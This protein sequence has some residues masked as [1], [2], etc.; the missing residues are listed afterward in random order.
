MKKYLLLPAILLTFFSTSKLIA[1]TQIGIT[2]ITDET[3]N[4]DKAFALAEFITQKKY[5]AAAGALEPKLVDYVYNTPYGLS[6]KLTKMMAIFVIYKD[7]K[8]IAQISCEN[9]WNLISAALDAEFAKLG[10]TASGSK[11]KIDEGDGIK[12][13]EKRMAGNLPGAMSFELPK[14]IHSDEFKINAAEIEYFEPKDITRE[15]KELHGRYGS[16]DITDSKFFKSKDIPKE[17]KDAVQPLASPVGKTM[18]MPSMYI[19]YG[20]LLMEQKDYET[21]QHCY[22]QAIAGSYELIGSS[23]DKA[24]IRAYAF[25]KLATLQTGL[26]SNRVLMAKLYNACAAINKSAKL[27]D[28][29]NKENA[30]YYSNVKTIQELCL[31]AEQNAKSARASRFTAAFGA[32]SS[33]LGQGFMSTGG[34]QYASLSSSV[35]MMQVTMEKSQEQLIEN[36]RFKEELRSVSMDINSDIFITDAGGVDNR[37]YFLAG[38]VYYFLSQYPDDVKDVLEEYATD[39]PALTKLLADYYGATTKPAKNKAIKDLYKHL[40]KIEYTISNFEARSMAV[41]EKYIA[42]F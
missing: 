16:A 24:N 35:Q 7:A 11:V 32:V 33:G 26:S 4:T 14:N 10:F 9:D 36:M 38:E 15:L 3:S 31:K 27:G 17:L 34:A 13:Y 1:Q 2:V 12:V 19:S 6:G 40:G 5:T 23:K 20:N 18:L 39:K 22:I 28:V 37:N 25:A 8:N 42:D 29:I 41:P 21:A 30:D